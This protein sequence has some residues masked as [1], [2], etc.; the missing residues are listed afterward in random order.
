MARED[1]SQHIRRANSIFLPIVVL[2]FMIAAASLAMSGVS[3]NNFKNIKAL[4]PDDF[5]VT[6]G[7]NAMTGT[8]QSQ[9]VIPSSTSSVGSDSLRYK[10]LFTQNIN[11]KPTSNLTMFDGP[12]TPGNFVALG[13]NGLLVDAKFSTANLANGPF[14]SLNGGTFEGDVNMLGHN[15]TNVSKLNGV[16][17]TLLMST[18]GSFGLNHIPIAASNMLV[19]SGVSSNDIV[20]TVSGGSLNNVVIFA[21]LKVVE[22]FA[23]DYKNIVQTESGGTLNNIVKY[24][25]NKYITDSEISIDDVASMSAMVP[26]LPKT[27]GTFTGVVNGVS[28]IASTPIILNGRISA[29]HSVSFTH[30]Q[31]KFL[32]FP[33]VSIQNPSG[34]FS[35][36]A[37]GAIT[38]SGPTQYLR[39]TYQLMTNNVIASGYADLLL[40]V[41]LGSPPVP[42]RSRL[43]QFEPGDNAT[44]KSITVVQVY[45]V[46]TGQTFQIAGQYGTGSPDTSILLFQSCNVAVQP[47]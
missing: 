24:S 42:V 37:S 19:D 25:G 36:G 32:G 12:V 7:T 39:I 11:G 15:F 35:V 30:D 27:G 14:M 1:E 16:E 21:G 47:I 13:S 40:W 6:T 20:T 31:P 45:Q 10:S 22:E 9:S 43:M 4:G 41:N 38:Y 3:F 44:L 29:T 5:V 33:F 23:T 28:F 2:L 17:T 18:Q 8:L 34:Q 46:A 26:Y